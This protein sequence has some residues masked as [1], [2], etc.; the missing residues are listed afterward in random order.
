MNSR[1]WM[2][3]SD[4]IRA[5]APEISLSDSLGNGSAASA[6]MVLVGLAD[7]CVNMSRDKKKEEDFEARSAGL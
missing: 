1:D 2:K 7:A 4:F 5:Q 3:L 6:S